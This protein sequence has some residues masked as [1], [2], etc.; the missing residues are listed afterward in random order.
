MSQYVMNPPIKNQSYAGTQHASRLYVRPNVYLPNSE[1]DTDTGM[2]CDS[3]RRIGRTQAL[4][5]EAKRLDAEYAKL[6]SMLKARSDEKGHHMS[7]RFAV[8][9]I[10][11][12]TL[13]FSFILLFQHGNYI[14]K[15]NTVRLLNNKIRSTQ[16][17]ISNLSAE[18]T[19]A[20]D[21]VQICY[22]AA[23]DLDMIP[24]ESAQAIYL[25]AFSTRPSQEPITIRASSD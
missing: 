8:V 13:L 3:R 6:Q 2:L 15:E 24:A 5:G 4:R 9:L 12:I 17:E 18:I 16:T 23:Q 10:I 20:S 19:K 1:I 22:A 25:T 14:A 7:L 11:C 21:P